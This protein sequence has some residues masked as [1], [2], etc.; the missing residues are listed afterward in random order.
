MPGAIPR[1]GASG[2]P[3]PT[4]VMMDLPDAR[5]CSMVSTFLVGAGIT[6]N[7]G[8]P[9]FKEL[10]Q[11]FLSAASIDVDEAT[12][13]SVLEAFPPE[14]LFYRLA[15]CDPTYKRSINATLL[16]YLTGLTPNRN[17]RALAIALHKGAKVWTTNYDTLVETAH[18]DEGFG[19]V[20]VLAPPDPPHCEDGSC[21]LRHLYKPHGTFR[22]DNPD[23]QRLIY[24]SPQVLEGLADEWTTAAAEAFS[25][26][27]I[28]AGYSGNDLDI[29]PIL[30]ASVEHS[31]GTWYEFPGPL[32]DHAQ[33]L[34]GDVM[35]IEPT[36]PS[37]GLQQL[38]RTQYRVADDALGRDP[39]VIRSPVEPV[40]FPRHHIATAAL[41]GQLDLPGRARDEYTASA[42]HDPLRFKRAAAKQL[43]RSAVFDL[44]RPNQAARYGF[45]AARALAPRRSQRVAAWRWELLANE[46]H[47]TTTK[48]A[49][50]ILKQGERI[51]L[52]L[53][54][55][56]ARTSAASLLKLA[57][58]LDQV[59]Q[60]I[61]A[62]LDALGPSALGKTIF[63]LLWTYRNRG[64]LTRWQALWDSNATSGPLMDPNWA[65]W[66]HIE[67]ADRAAMIDDHA[68]A[69]DA[70]N[71]VS[72][73]FARQR[74]HPRFIVDYQASKARNDALADDKTAARAGFDDLLRTLDNDRQL[75]T[76]F[77]RAS[78]SIAR[79]SLE[80]LDGDASTVRRLIEQAEHYTPSLLHRPFI[81][82]LRIRHGLNAGSYD[83]LLATT[84]ETGFGYG[85][86]IVLRTTGRADT[87]AH[88]VG[89]QELLGRWSTTPQ[90]WVVP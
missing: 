72:T 77:R 70:L 6:Y 69:I 73:Q 55:Q 29:M 40:D 5:K 85:E 46:A 49:A 12:L 35:H 66:L 44:E 18:R 7:S 48:F 2:D 87:E 54:G 26:E 24:E 90:V 74:A 57:G 81:E 11:A 52:E 64:E 83:T 4:C 67:A 8:G 16:R 10:W 22:G 3:T 32:A 50:R 28:V 60:F 42:L 68:T 61:D 45:R 43:I 23:R 53:W 78:F 76:P 75:D 38:V 88:L 33:H 62:D 80:P 71:H 41:L 25:N 56:P 86:A 1:S 34:V 63:N 13:D 21:R 17:H 9:T 84:R 58:R 20:H 14:Q 51:P 59:D 82:L 39:S 37:T 15:S 19:D 30:A 79:A 31:G 36:N 47:G 27:T 89:A 65:A